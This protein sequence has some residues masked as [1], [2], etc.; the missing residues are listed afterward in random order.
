[1]N[2]RSILKL[3][4]ALALLEAV[5][6]GPDTTVIYQVTDSQMGFGARMSGNPDAPATDMAYETGK[7]SA[8]VEKINATSPDAVVFT[9]DL[10][11]KYRSEEQWSEF[12]R[13]ESGLN[14]E[15]EKYYIP[16][17]HDVGLSGDS[18]DLSVW[19]DKVGD[20]R[21][22]AVVGNSRIIGI[23]TDY[24]KYSPDSEEERLQEEWLDAQLSAKSKCEYTFV[25][26]H[27]P[28]FLVTAD[29]PEAYFNLR[30][31]LRERYICIFE[32]NNVDAV[33]S[34]HKHENFELCYNGKPFI[35]TSAVGFPLGEDPSGV[36][37]IVC[38]KDAFYQAFLAIEEIPE[39]RTALIDKVKGL[40]TK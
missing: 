32:K 8:A 37:V 33:L 3:A 24:S 6:C 29:E 40:A 31:D 38:E 11:D 16:G 19:K 1:M 30:P 15:I 20:D 36:R 4:A 22:A 2:M 9:G 39:S 14:P 26:A 12:R 13:I 17:N 25:F 21:F 18:V 28:F 5:S 10:V 35:T 27:H 23:N 7:F 34:G